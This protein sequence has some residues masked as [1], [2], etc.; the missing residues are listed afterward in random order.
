ME[1][2]TDLTKLS[3]K[4]IKA[5]LVQKQEE[6]RI[7]R[8]AKKQNYEAIRNDTVERLTAKAQTIHDL[9]KDF[10]QEAFND[11]GALLEVLQEYSERYATGKG[12]FTAMNSDGTMKIE[13]QCH[14]LGHF[15]ERS[16]PAKK[17]I[18]DFLN[19]KFGGDPDTKE[20]YSSLLQSDDNGKLDIKMVQRLYKFEDKWND[21]NWKLG[22]KLLKESWTPSQTRQY[23][24]FEIKVNGVWQAIILDI[25]RLPLNN[26]I[27]K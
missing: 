14:E 5:L 18:L 9:L 2:T 26:I 16:D 24:R 17:H 12:N 11:M 22:I 6:E 7:E 23:I 13:F 27:T 8:E 1:T 20:L 4:E 10:K 25:A 21:E 15:D 3:A 19:S